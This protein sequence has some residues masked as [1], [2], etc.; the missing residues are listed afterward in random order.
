M[1]RNLMEQRQ[2]RIFQRRQ[3]PVQLSLWYQPGRQSYKQVVRSRFGLVEPKS[4]TRHSPAIQPPKT[5]HWDGTNRPNRLQT[6]RHGGLFMQFLPTKS[7][8]RTRH[9]MPKNSES[10]RYSPHCRWARRS[11]LMLLRSSLCS[12][13]FVA[14]STNDM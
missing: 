3:L 2:S 10:N 14:F 5:P 6:D 9:E 12:T 7:I 8:E 4:G 13:S 1:H 11:A